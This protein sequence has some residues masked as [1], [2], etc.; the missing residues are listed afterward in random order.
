MIRINLMPEELRPVKRSALPHLLSLVLLALVV[1][2]L[3]SNAVG[4]M[5]A[6]A[7]LTR[8]YEK[9][10]QELNQLSDVV[11]EYNT[12]VEEKK[13]FGERIGVIQD[14]LKD[15]TLW[16]EWL[17]ELVRLTPDN[18]WYSRIRLTSRKFTEERIKM[19]KKGEPMVDPKTK[20]PAT[21]KV[22]IDKPILE[23]TGYA[24]E[25]ESGVSS[26]AQLAENTSESE[27]FASK[28]SLYAS[29]IEDTD[30]NGFAV[31]KFIFEYII[32]Q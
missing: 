17:A 28:F 18:I 1:F 6:V 4:Q 22:Q 21:E 14:I 27:R 5:A 15:R 12:L 24:V 8:Q 19:D 29:R 10:R 26:T 32:Q 11:K 9:K 25:N 23:V 20:K 2:Y 3:A 7:S 30:F 16:S 13:A 31:R